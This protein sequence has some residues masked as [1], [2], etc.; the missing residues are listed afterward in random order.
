MN[1]SS[2]EL[3]VLQTAFI[4]FNNGLFFFETKRLLITKNLFN[5]QQHCT[6]DKLP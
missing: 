1:K 5:E 2:F 4:S 6:A 3:F